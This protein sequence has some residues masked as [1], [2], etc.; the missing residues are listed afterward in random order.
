MNEIKE[1]LLKA[2][3]YIINYI[4]Y[5]KL[6]VAIIIVILLIY[7]IWYKRV[8]SQYS[9]IAWKIRKKNGKKSIF[10]YDENGNEVYKKP[11]A[12]QNQKRCPK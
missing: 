2:H 5:K 12:K 11:K 1:T 9:D 4:G 8:R 3:Q 6:V 7:L 10:W